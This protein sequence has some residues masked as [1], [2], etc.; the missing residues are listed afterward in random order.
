M[1]ERVSERLV[2]V[3]GSRQ[4]QD[5]G[6]PPWE[7]AKNKAW[8][9]RRMEVYAAMVDRMD[10]GIGRIVGALRATGALDNVAAATS[11][12]GDP[13]ATNDTSSVSTTVTEQADL[14]VV[15]TSS[16]NPVLPGKNLTYDITVTNN[17]PAK[18]ENVSLRDTLPT[19][20]ISG[21]TVLVEPSD[22]LIAEG[23]WGFVLL[24]PGNKQVHAIQDGDGDQCHR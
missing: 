12:T 15:K 20:P 22:N 14:S 8:H 17:G 19:D 1:S 10:Q 16:P 6:V 13:D 2:R 9:E 11:D 21:L 23:F 5:L 24:H 4:L 7:E 3:D 18:V